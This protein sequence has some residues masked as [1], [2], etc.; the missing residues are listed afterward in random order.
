MKVVRCETTKLIPSR[1]HLHIRLMHDLSN[2]SR[3]QVSPILLEELEKKE[4]QVADQVFR[5]AAGSGLHQQSAVS[6]LSGES[7]SQASRSLG[8][9]FR[10]PLTTERRV[11]LIAKWWGAKFLQ[12]V[13]KDGFSIVIVVRCQNCRVECLRGRRPIIRKR[14]IQPALGFPLTHQSFLIAGSWP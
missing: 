6:Q 14:S 7:T 13:K 11:L 10:N 1:S 2:Q 8:P 12:N 5:Q 4:V 9:L 3:K